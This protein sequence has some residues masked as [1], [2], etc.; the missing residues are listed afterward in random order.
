MNKK[1][2][3]KRFGFYTKYTRKIGNN[4]AGFSCHIKKT[5]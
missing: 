3:V 2:F 5:Y 4:P 1:H